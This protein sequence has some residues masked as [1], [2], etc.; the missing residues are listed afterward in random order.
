MRPVSSLSSTAKAA[1]AKVGKES[2][3]N[4]K[5]VICATDDN[6]VVVLDEPEQLLNQPTN[7]TANMDK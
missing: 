3:A 7:S 5:A 6:V 1:L 2:F 4:E